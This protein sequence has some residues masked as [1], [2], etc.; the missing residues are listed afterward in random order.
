MA[1]Y[2]SCAE[3]ARL[4][5]A[6][7][8]EAFPAV[9]FSVR[10]KTYSGGASINV[11]WTDGPCGADVKAI[12]GRFEGSYFD[13]MTDYKGCNYNEINGEAVTFAADYVFT[14]RLYTAPVLTGIV[15]SVLNEYGLDAN[16]TISY[17]P[18]FGARVSVVD[19]EPETASRGFDVRVVE[20]LIGEAM[21]SYS[22]V[23]PAESA[24]VSSVRFVGDD[25]YGYGAVGVAA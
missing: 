13:G 10:S 23:A 3:T 11:E 15:S 21:A 25:G 6:A 16:V 24:T 12:V 1:K 4:V 20:R 7:L 14:S 22:E 18:D 9:R 8:K 17:S 2:L 5:R 19:V